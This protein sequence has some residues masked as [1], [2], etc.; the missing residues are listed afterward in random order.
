M[1]IPHHLERLAALNNLSWFKTLL[2]FR[3]AHHPANGE[4]GSLLVS[5]KDHSLPSFASSYITYT[6]PWPRIGCL[7][8]RNEHGDHHNRDACRRRALPQGRRCYPE[9]SRGMSGYNKYNLC[10][11]AIWKIGTYTN[12][13]RHAGLHAWSAKIGRRL[14]LRIYDMLE[15]FR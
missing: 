3:K 8:L 5:R 7:G 14:H 15:Q 2:L 10:F 4:H 12:T 11:V 13:W 1:A 6:W 9:A